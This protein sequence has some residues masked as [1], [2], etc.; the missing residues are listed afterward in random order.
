MRP[1]LKLLALLLL[2]LGFACSGDEGSAAGD[3]TTEATTPELVDFAGLQE[4]LMPSGQEKALLVNF[5]A[6]W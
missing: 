6:T 2:P 3:V 5:W 4:R 1:P